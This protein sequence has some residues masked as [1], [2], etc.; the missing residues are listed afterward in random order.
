[1]ENNP[2]RPEFPVTQLF[3]DRWSARAMSG[4]GISDTELMSL[5]EAARWA[6]S[7]YNNQPWRFVY[8][9]RNTR[10]WDTLFNLMTPGNQS[11]AKNAAVLVVVL[12]HKLFDYDNSPSATHSFDTGAACE[13]MALQGSINKLVV[14]GMAGFDYDRARKELMVPDD[15]AVEAMFAIGRPGKKEDLPPELAKREVPSDRKKVHEIVFEGVFKAP[16]QK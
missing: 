3:L 1:M 6:Q 2:R 5:F 15:Y 4:E 14:H 12:S 10:A 8:A 7:C 11:W 9:K 13:N 16:K